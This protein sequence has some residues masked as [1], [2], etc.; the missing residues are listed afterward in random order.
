MSDRP[1]RLMWIR[2]AMFDQDSFNLTLASASNML[3]QSKD[4]SCVETVESMNFY[5]ASVE[6]VS[7][8]LRDPRD[9]ISNELVGTILGFT[10]LDVRIC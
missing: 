6:A 3:A 5:T 2:L 8:R 1:I 4:P 10:C 7:R 9:R